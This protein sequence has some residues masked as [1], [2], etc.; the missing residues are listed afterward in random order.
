MPIHN[1]IVTTITI[2]VFASY[3]P[4][5]A[6]D[7]QTLIQSRNMKTN[8]SKPAPIMIPYQ[9]TVTIEETEKEGDEITKHKG[10]Y[11]VDPLAVAGRRI[12]FLN[13]DFDFSEDALEGIRSLNEKETTFEL[14]DGFWC[15]NSNDDEFY[16]I[17]T[18]RD[19][20]ILYEDSESVI[21]SIGNR[22]YWIVY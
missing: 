13:D 4:S 17:V 22:P 18:A 3:Q 12:T 2:L 9:Y 10:S 21:L 19:S 6:Q 8:I 1:F 14:S 20:Q 16:K 15:P 11:R 7:F 5:F